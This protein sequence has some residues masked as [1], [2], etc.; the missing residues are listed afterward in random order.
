[1]SGM[2][3]AGW[4]LLGAP[5]DCSG[6]DRGESRAPG[7][8]RAAGLTELVDQD[9]GDAATQID[10]TDRDAGSGVLALP[11][12]VRAARALAD[13]LTG[14][15][16]GALTGGLTGASADVRLDG[17]RPLVVGGDCSILLGIYPA[18][19]RAGR[20]CRSVVRRRSSRLLGRSGV[21]HG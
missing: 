5:W 16:I 14:A 13:A 20:S 6:T 9:L 10:S 21:G 4:Y 7:A 19:R 12:T 11:E 1:M 15:L 17:K 18:L 2:T 8:L 3:P